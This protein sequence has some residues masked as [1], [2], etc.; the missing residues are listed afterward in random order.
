M[1]NNQTTPED[2]ISTITHLEVGSHEDHAAMC[3]MEAVAYVAGEPWSDSPACAC[4]VIGAFLRAWNDGLPDDER[5]ALLL[6]LIPRLIGTRTTPDIERRR[7]ILA[8]DWLVRVHTPAWLRLASLDKH[9]DAIASLPEITDLTQCPSIMP[10]VKAARED[11]HAARDAARSAAWDAA[12]DAAREAAGDA[13]GGAALGAARDAAWDAARDA[14][15]DA[16]WAAAGGAALGA[17]GGAARDAAWDA[18]WAAA[19]DAAGGAALGAARDAAWDAAWAAA[20]DALNPTRLEL[21]RSALALVERM[22]ATVA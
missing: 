2:K 4:P 21:Q 20:G 19:W 7:A 8:A 15:W 17:A 13:A 5:D 18:A 12:W 11:A 10:A 9:A 14:A 6:P 16:A 3:V 1:S 22:I